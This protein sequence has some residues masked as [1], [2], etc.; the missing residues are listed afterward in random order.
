MTLLG[1]RVGLGRLMC[2]SVVG[3][4]G[5]AAR[6]TCSQAG[7]YNIPHKAIN[8][9]SHACPLDSSST[10]LI[11]RQLAHT[12]THTHYGIAMGRVCVGGYTAG[13]VFCHTCLC[14]HGHSKGKEG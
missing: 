5:L 3:R 6:E 11:H 1:R 8:D 13:T 9:T 2:L 7:H 10:P 4:D 14:I 12:R